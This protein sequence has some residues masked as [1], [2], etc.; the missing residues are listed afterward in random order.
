MREML[1]PSP[2]KGIFA[3]REPKSVLHTYM[4]LNKPEDWI[5]HIDFS[6]PARA[7]AR[8]A[9]EFDGWAPKL[10][11]LITD[12][13]TAPGHRP[14]HSLPVEHRWDRVP[15]LTLLD[16]AAHLTPPNGEGAN[17]AMYD[18]AELG[19]ALA[20]HADDVEA[21]LAE[22]EQAIFL[23]ST[24]AATEGAKAFEMLSGDNSLQSLLDFFTNNQP[25]K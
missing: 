21:A 4:I 6:V 1:A 8:V 7:L 18:G 9:Q 17:L 24:E 5:P 12:G 13:E 25:A 2:G 23:C 15:G 14:F 16:D 19:K 10:R 11:V 20:A 22:Y 3:H